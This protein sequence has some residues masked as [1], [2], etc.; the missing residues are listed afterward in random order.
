MTFAARSPRPGSVSET[1]AGT[2]AASLLGTS[3]WRV[4][5]TGGAVAVVVGVVALL[6]PGVT[7]AAAGV[8]FGVFLLSYGITQIVEAFG[9]HAHPTSR[10]LLVVSGT[11]STLLGLMCFH[12]LARSLLLL[13]V[14]I[15]FGWILRGVTLAVATFNGTEGARG[16]AARSV[17]AAVSVLAGLTVVVWPF[18][19]L[20]TLV[21]VAG[22]W[23]IVTGVL[24]IA[25]G[26]V[27]RRSA[28]AARR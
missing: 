1:P 3:A 4:A 19:S 20:A 13:A 28:A 26:M 24:E 25:H 11:L 27:L 23:L 2:R 7:L 6:W 22:I 5:I 15:G 12:S 16:T 14:W 21:L 18:S 10:G 17:L 9:P 8:F